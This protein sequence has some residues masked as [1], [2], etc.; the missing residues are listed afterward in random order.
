[1][2]KINTILSYINKCDELY[3]QSGNLNEIKNFID[4]VICV[5]NNEIPGFTAR[6]NTTDP[7]RIYCAINIEEAKS[8]LKNIKAMLNNYKD[9]IKGGILNSKKAKT[10][11]NINSVSSAKAIVDVNITLDQVINNINELPN[12]ILSKE[13]K[14]DLDDK[15]R[16]LESVV[17]SGDKEKIKNKL[18]KIF[19]FALEK[20]PAV[21]GLVSSAV[22]LLNEKILPLFS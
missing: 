6:L 1:M 21:I 18:V 19:N 8:D 2:S 4:E 5:Y 10:E 16:A 13:E 14:D 11:I 20:G 17:N 7:S 12:D 3:V 15:L 22:S 9:N